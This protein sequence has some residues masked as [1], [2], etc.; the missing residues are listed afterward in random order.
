VP[1]EMWMSS[2][3]CEAGSA[4]C[5]ERFGGHAASVERCLGYRIL[6]EGSAWEFYAEGLD[7]R[8][9]SPDL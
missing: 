7:R 1:G 5:V 8:I 3:E 4:I 2:K 9:D 6:D